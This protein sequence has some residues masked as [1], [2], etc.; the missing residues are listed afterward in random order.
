MD[1]RLEKCCNIT[2]YEAQKEMGIDPIPAEGI[3]DEEHEK[4]ATK[5]LEEYIQLFK[6]NPK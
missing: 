1:K 3:R 2:K 4:R 6:A 5:M